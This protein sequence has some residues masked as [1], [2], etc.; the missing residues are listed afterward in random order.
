MHGVFS[1]LQFDEIS[2]PERRDV[3]GVVSGVRVVGFV[4]AQDERIREADAVDGVCEGC[5]FGGF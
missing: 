2:R 1:L 4:L 3:S 5:G